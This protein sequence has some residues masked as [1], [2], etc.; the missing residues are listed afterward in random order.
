MRIEELRVG[1]YVLHND[2]IIEIYNIISDYNGVN[3]HM[4]YLYY[5]DIPELKPIQLTEE[6]LLKCEGIINHPTIENRYELEDYGIYFN[7]EDGYWDEPSL[8]V[9][10]N[11]TYITCVEFLHQ[12]QNLYFALTNQELNIEL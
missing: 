5:I 4:D 7:I 1:N 3:M 10:I 6:I 12:L 9:L 2:K 8:D 11:G